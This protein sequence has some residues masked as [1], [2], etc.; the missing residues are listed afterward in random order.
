MYILNK[1]P[2][3]SVIIPTYNDL[4][5]LKFAISSVLSQDFT[6]YE[7]LVIDNYSTDGTFTY[8]SVLDCPVLRLFQISNSGIIAKSRNYGIKHAN[9]KWLCFLDSDDSWLPSKLSTIYSYIN[10]SV[11]IIAH[12]MIL[13]PLSYALF[14]RKRYI[15]RNIN[16]DPLLKLVTNGNFLV[17]S[18]VSVSKSFLYEYQLTMLEDENL[19]AVE[20]FSLWLQIF[21]NK[22][23][24]IY[25]CKSLGYYRIH[26]SNTSALRDMS[27]PVANLFYT[28]SANFS[29]KLLRYAISY[30]FYMSARYRQKSNSF[31]LPHR[32]FLYVLRS[33]SLTIKLKYICLFL[34][35][36][37]KRLHLI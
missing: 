32:Q 8:I 29:D 12:D 3:F 19:I 26:N 20:D 1:E 18:S 5:H 25:L 17:T 11:H 36:F 7:I 9:G 35:F 23:N 21:L 31:C 15:A 22:G 37:L 30:T 24:L 14:N 34:L 6:D 33:G 28:L 2:F 27:V 13:L 16:T 10:P 4:A